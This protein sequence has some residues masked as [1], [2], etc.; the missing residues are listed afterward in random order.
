MA[1]VTFFL[2]SESIFAFVEK[3]LIQMG[4]AFG[5]RPS[6]LL[7]AILLGKIMA[8]AIDEEP[9]AVNM[10]VP[11]HER[12]MLQ[13]RI[14]A[15]P[16]ARDGQTFGEFVVNLALGHYDLREAP[17]ER[18]KSN[19]RARQPRCRV[20]GRP[21]KAPEAIAAGIG[22]VCMARMRQTAA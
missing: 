18:E 19:G 9:L 22:P 2:P 6:Q 16:E 21:L 15:W 3:K 5:L 12:D 1:D 13:Q 20:C 4:H 7:R 10:D 14:D 11:D 17:R 8:A